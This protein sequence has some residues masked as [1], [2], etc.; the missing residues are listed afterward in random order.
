MQLSYRG[1]SYNQNVT[2]VD[3]VDS[4]MT[5]S[6]RGRTYSLTYPRHI[7]VAQPAHNLVYRG[8]AY[9]TNAMSGAEPAVAPK[10]AVKSIPTSTIRIPHSL[11]KGS[12]DSVHKLNIQRRLQQRIEAAKARGDQRLLLLLEREMQQ[13]G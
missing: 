7:P 13:A 1:T 11:Q 3:M 10:P 9:Q 12:Y 8:V 2:P 4:G 5:A 6:Y